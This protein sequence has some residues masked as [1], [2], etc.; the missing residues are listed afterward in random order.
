MNVEIK[1]QSQQWMHTH[2]PSKPKKFKQ[3]LSACQKDDGNSFLGQEGCGDGGIHAIRDHN[4][5]RSVLKKMRRAIQNK[6]CGMLTHSIL[7]VV[8]HDMHARI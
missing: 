1:Q 5:A 4:N 7:S 2:S 6:R 8:L 3:R